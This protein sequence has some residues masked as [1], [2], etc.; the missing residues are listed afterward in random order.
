MDS[1]SPG[2]SPD[3]S[4][5]AEA[6]LAAIVRCS[7][8]VIVSKDLAGTVTSWNR[9]AEQLFGYT[10][11]EAVGRSITLIIPPERHEE[12]RAILERLRRG[13][14]IDH[15]ETVRM[16]KDGRRI[17]I[18]LTISPVLDR[19]GN[20]IGASKIGREIGER[21]R[22]QQAL[23]EAEDRLRL[24][25]EAAGF[26][27][28][29]RDLATG[30]NHWS[31][32]LKTLFGLPPG[33]ETPADPVH[34][35]LIHP[36]DAER[37]H[38]KMAASFD[39]SGDGLFEDEHR[40]IR[41]DGSTRW[42]LVKGRTLFCG[43]GHARRG[44]RALG[45]VIDITDRRRA[46]ETATDEGRIAETLNRI[47]NT[48]AAEHELER[49][50]QLVTDEATALANAEFGAFFYN[51]VNDEG[52]S[53]TLYTLSG[54]P[55]E[56][57]GRLPMPRNTAI[58]EP[59]FRGHG[60]LRLDDVT[61]DPRY[62]RNPPYQGMP[63]G[64]PPVRSHLAAPVVSRGGA[65]LGG[66]F[67]GHSRPGVFT[68][69]HERIVTGIAAQAA[70][71][72][73]NAQLYKL[74]QEDI[75]R[76]NEVEQ[77]LRAS[78][79]RH[80]Q[81]LALLPVAVY[82]CQ[83]PSGV[84][85][86]YN[87]QA[88]KLWG[89]EPQPGDTDER[90]CGSHKLFRPDGTFLPHA[91]CPMAVALREGRRY[92]NC[93]VV[94]E[95]QNG[96]RVDALVNIDPILDADGRIVGAV[97][98][99]HDVSPLKQAQRALRETDRRKDE[100]LATLAHELRNPLAPL[101]HMLE[102]MKQADGDGALLQRARETME[103]QVAQMVRLIDDLLD[104]SRITRNRLEL[105][106]APVDLASVLQHA[107][108]TCRPLL[109]AR[110][111]KLRIDAPA[112]QIVLRADAARLG[113]VFSNLLDNA[114]KYTEPGGSI[115]IEVEER[116]GSVEVTVADHGA[117]IP[118]DQLETIF[119][120]FAQVERPT[121]G[122]REGLGIGLT[123]VRQL[124]AMHGGEVEA[125]SPGLGAGSRFAVRLPVAADSGRPEAAASP[126]APAAGRRRILVVDDNR[127]AALSLALLL[128][129]GGHE[130]RTAHDGAEALQAAE[131]FQPHVVLLDIGL[132]KMNG[133]DVC[134]A[135]RSRPWGKEIT[136]VAVTGWGQPKDRQ[137]SKE[138]GFDEHLV[139][140]VEPCTLQAV[141]GS[142]ARPA[143]PAEG[144]A[145]NS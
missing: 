92:R 133:Y 145:G 72:I 125:F 80:R 77:A 128:Q 96:S 104:L 100:F 24:A 88:A 136:L 85:N 135:I 12:E 16:A 40:I 95:R 97:N 123:I 118:R 10:A 5:N 102:V 130:T 143:Q 124:V 59:T 106:K 113:Q 14:T 37:V 139:K 66:L 44:G 138:A 42:V 141:V 90:F 34:A 134:R 26:G 33:A 122:P 78:E 11:A 121:A 99:F 28:Y 70:I 68:E 98:V 25:A 94:L 91:E 120:M 58:F 36:Q 86:Y 56:A 109:E 69:R 39:P 61:Q 101:R 111:H 112:G 93:E 119:E 13:E 43:T 53:Y 127:D 89:R 79:E 76:R 32:S 52:E 55:R 116:A 3:A 83:A 62:G 81:L 17:A 105:R 103:Q 64:H 57:F 21:H 50:V 84:I 41:P 18:S 117:G 47:G 71:A 15:C 27:T 63:E 110:G 129:I 107:V 20:I 19:A 1:L 142:G 73:D 132:P 87:E 51:L 49:I 131:A 22:A 65:V 54:V 7:D 144:E 75:A 6:L 126:A 29:E 23:R 45:T 114:C 9:A 31:E 30:V 108:E 67:F 82:T 115:R 60:V 140:P 48:L 74:L 46:E 4:Q 35:G 2:C 8:D 137:I 38:A